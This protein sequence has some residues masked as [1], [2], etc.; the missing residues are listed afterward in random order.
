MSRKV[1]RIVGGVIGALAVA[2]A[3]GVSAQYL[4]TNKLVPFV[5]PRP[6]AQQPITQLVVKYKN[7]TEA[8]QVRSVT[9][10][11]LDVLSASAGVKLTY[12]RPMGGAAHV[13]YLPQAMTVNEAQA[14]AAKIAANP[15]VEY[16]EP[17]YVRRALLVPNDPGYSPGFTFGGSQQGT[18]GQWGLMAPTGSYTYRAIGAT[19][20][21][22]MRPVGGA[23]LPAAWDI[24]KGSGAVIGVVDTGLTSHTDLNANMV[25]GSPAL[26][27]Y[28]FISANVP[29]VT[30][31]DTNFTANDGDGRD[32]DPSD[33]GDWTAVGD[34][35]TN[36]PATAE[37]S[38]W[39]GTHVSGTIAAVSNNNVGVAGIAYQAKVL[40]AR[41]LG[42]CGG[43][44]SD[45]SDA[46]R[47]AAGA[48]VPGVPTNTNPAKVVSLSLGGS[49]QSGPNICSNTE[50]NAVNA[51]RAAG[52]VVVA[53]TGND[54]TANIASPSSCVG[55]IAVTAHTIEGDKAD[56]ANYGDSG[57]GANGQAPKNSTTI[58]APGGGCG[59]NIT[60]STTPA[61]AD[62][63]IWST[64][65]AGAQVPST[66]AYAGAAGTSMATPH[67][68]GVAGL[69]FS[70][71]PSL[72]PDTVKDLLTSTARAFPA[73]T[74]C[75]SGGAGFGKC[76]A[77]MLDATAAV[78]QLL[79]NQPTVN[80]G[81]DQSAQGRATVTLTG[82]GALSSNYVASGLTYAW[83]QVSGGAVTLATPNA[84]TTT[85][86]ANNTSETLAFTLTVTDSKGYAK[87]A[88]THV[89]VTAVVDPT[90]PTTGGGG[91]GGGA[92]GLLG[93]GLL[94]LGAWGLRR[95]RALG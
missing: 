47:W 88:T 65:N 49:T 89:T 79:A 9:A 53:A 73:G 76:G 62:Q 3:V 41:A 63:Y 10:Q 24:T 17:D 83:K 18:Q 52:A 7:E 14:I 19:S 86:T 33:P 56:Y 82:S 48:S 13:L 29:S 93:L 77:G 94:A 12:K 16:A 68:A 8:M 34:C 31:T 90:P 22:T 38:S 45:I 50:Q 60:A 75:A 95:N 81:S 91:G 92:V 30:S 57:D 40:M 55:V 84:A 26:S 44:S 72:L 11:R 43:R 2:S 42:K 37:N 36:E 21:T 70:L 39:H 32:S 25:G 5:P 15:N 61:C 6:T 23:N 66:A 46:I 78:T 71:N 54:G 27:G 28:D 51:A 20:T 35:G 58:S 80:A 85:F 69:L 64:S 1:R 74:Y 59:T 67:V 4:N 87:S